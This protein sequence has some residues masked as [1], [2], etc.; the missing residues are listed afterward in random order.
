MPASRTDG[1]RFLRSAATPRFNE[2][3]TSALARLASD[4]GA[5]ADHAEIEGPEA[6]VAEP[7]SGRARATAKRVDEPRPDSDQESGH[8]AEAADRIPPLD[9]EIAQHLHILGEVRVE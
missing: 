4:A 5:G 6:G 3:S 7:R 1:G 9:D 8:V 2:W